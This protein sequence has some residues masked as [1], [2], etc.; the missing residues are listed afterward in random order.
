LSR[1]LLFTGEGWDLE[2]ARSIVDIHATIDTLITGMEKGAM[3]QHDGQPEYHFPGAL[4]KMTPRL[5][6][7]GE[8]H[9]IKRSA[10]QTNSSEQ[11]LDKDPVTASE[12]AIQDIMFPLPHG[13]SWRILRPP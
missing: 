7:F 11:S 3:A 9:K 4:A 1:L 13:L 6:A 2:H 12:D 10:L 8:Y 5:R